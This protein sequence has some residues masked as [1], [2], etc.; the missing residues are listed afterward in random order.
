MFS[1]RSAVEIVVL[2]VSSD[3]R[4]VQCTRSRSQPALSGSNRWRVV[5]LWSEIEPI[6][7]LRANPA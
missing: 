2:E 5:E 4:G 6:E 1:L 7:G 3:S